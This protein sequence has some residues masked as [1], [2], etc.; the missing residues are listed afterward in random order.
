[1]SAKSPIIHVH[2]N[3]YLNK[4]AT[5]NTV[6]Q[7][8]HFMSHVDPGYVVSHLA[9]RFDV[10]QYNL[11][12]FNIFILKLFFKREKAVI[13]CFFKFEGKNFNDTIVVDKKSKTKWMA[14]W[15]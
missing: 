5:I 10:F 1:M 13:A 15:T 3:H 8:L 9:L 4:N 6:T 11:M 12:Y 7:L 2:N 14:K